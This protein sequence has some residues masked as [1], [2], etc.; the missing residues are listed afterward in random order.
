MTFEDFL[1]IKTIARNLITDKNVVVSPLFKIRVVDESINGVTIIF[2]VIGH[3]DH[4]NHSL[5]YL[6]KN[7][8]LTKID[9]KKQ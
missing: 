2:D 4:E 6:V 9:S 3:Q 7:N 1:R 5:R 8:T